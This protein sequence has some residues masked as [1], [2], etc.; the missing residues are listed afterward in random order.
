MPGRHNM[1]W[2]GPFVF[3]LRQLTQLTVTLQCLTDVDSE[4]KN[5]K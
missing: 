2:Y 4:E 5:N 3:I 1:C